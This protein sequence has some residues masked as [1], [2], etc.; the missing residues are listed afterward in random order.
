MLIYGPIF[1]CHF[2][3]YMIVGKI[4]PRYRFAILF[5]TFII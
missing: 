2:Q 3:L 4:S 5:S 1:S